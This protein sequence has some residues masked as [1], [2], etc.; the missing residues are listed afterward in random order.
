[1][2]DEE[3]L[4]DEER[5]A[6]VRLFRRQSQSLAD[7]PALIAILDTYEQ[8]NKPPRDWRKRWDEMKKTPRVRGDT[9][10]I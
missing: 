5:K 1:M 6:I 7:L 9:P 8:Q 3:P 4:A 10:R 2:T